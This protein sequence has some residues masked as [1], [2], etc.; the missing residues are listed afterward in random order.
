MGLGTTGLWA[1]GLRFQ[2]HGHSSATPLRS[3]LCLQEGPKGFIWVGGHEGL[4]RYDG[5]LLRSY[6][7]SDP[8]VSDTVTA[9]GLGP[10][11]LLWTGHED[12]RLC[13]LS[14]DSLRPVSLPERLPRARITGLHSDS[15]GVLW[16]ATYGAGIFACRGDQLWHFTQAE[17]LLGDEVYDL[18]P[19]AQGR[20]WV[21]T[22]RGI[23]RLWLAQGQ[24][25]L[26]TLPTALPDPLVLSL[27]PDPL[28]GMWLGTYA[29]G[30]VYL[31][32][33]GAV[34]HALP[35]SEA[36]SYGPVLSLLPLGQE[37]W[38][39]SRASGL[40]IL[41][42]RTLQLRDRYDRTHRFGNRRVYDMHQ[43]R[44][45]NVWLS[46]EKEPLLS[47]YPYLSA[48]GGEE[49]IR[50]LL[51]LPDGHRYLATNDGLYVLSGYGASPVPVTG[52]DWAGAG[53][54]ISL[55]QDHRGWVWAGTYGGGIYGR[56]PGQTAWRAYG[57]AEGLPDGSILS[58]ASNGEALWVATLAG[59][60]YL[61]LD[62]ADRFIPLDRTRSPALDYV[63]Q[64]KAAPDGSLWFATD[65][66]GLVHRDRSGTFRVFGEKEGI[67]PVIYS[68]SLDDQGH[69]WA[70]SPDTVLI[71]WDG[72]TFQRYGPSEG[73]RATDLTSVIGD[74]QGR[75][76]VVHQG[77]IDVLDQT[78]ETFSYFGAE[79]G[80]E[81]LDPDLNAYARDAEG[82]IWLGTQAGLLRYLPPPAGELTQPVTQLDAVWIYLSER[83]DTSLHVFPYE[84]RHL[85][86]A[87]T[88]L[89]YREP[90][91]VG[92]E[93][94]LE[95]YD[96]AWVATRDR[97]VTFPR[98]SPGTYTFRVRAAIN[99]QFEQATVASY[100]FRIQRPF[101]Q[102]YWF[103]GLVLLLVTG[104]FLAAIRQRE[105]RLRQQAHLEQ[106]RIR[107]QFETLRSQVNP[108]FLF[109]SFNTLISLIEDE[110]RQAVSYAN[111]LSDLFRNMLAFRERD[112]LALKEELAVL[113]TYFS[114]QQ[115]RYGANLRLDLDIPEA[116]QAHQLP[117]LTLQLLI[118]NAIKHNVIARARPLTIRVGIVEEDYLEVS[119]PLQPKRQ[120]ERS[121]GMGLPT[122]RARYKILTDRTV[123][124][125]Q[126]DGYFAVRVPLLPPVRKP[127]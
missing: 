76:L 41:S 53:G 11:G 106:E 87:Y 84:D 21:A 125:S 95:G 121:T 69:L 46:G 105:G 96:P 6:V 10:D 45:G 1:Q 4:F 80:L 61:P 78:R 50:C 109:N 64:I 40:L 17:G 18:A 2:R 30:P 72:Q 79:W 13:R 114:L 112:L 89:W 68:I 22:D 60:A 28:G 19:D 47:V 90:E 26:D 75:I 15:A 59:V 14:G 104:G 82:V 7:P 23:N 20:I 38:V 93:H 74:G 51:A 107:F 42:R 110:P 63:Y 67:P 108:H 117:P 77:G 98:L 29:R 49:N 85:T 70:G 34:V 92:Y 5:D 115:Q 126:E 62:G 111:Q 123:K 124:I 31:E 57:R 94:Q 127:G 58:I 100:R 33:G 8:T 88:G 25:R 12:G 102:T 71:H 24:P 3:A 39:G 101:W 120:P 83:V 16:V 103:W 65:G 66:G 9:L 113:R 99:G 86:F 54:V 43:D 32:P 118:E 48:V 119:N 37:V 36:W 97:K 91:A 27:C 116:Y 56:S 81:N 73:L 52:V 35:A 122:I 44:F 55:Y